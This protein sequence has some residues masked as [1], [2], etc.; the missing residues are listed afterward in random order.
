MDLGDDHLNSLSSKPLPP[1][2]RE[3]DFLSVIGPQEVELGNL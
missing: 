1:S 2:L 3:A